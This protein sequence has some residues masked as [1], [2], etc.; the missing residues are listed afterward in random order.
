MQY[1]LADEYRFTWRLLLA[2]RQLEDT[3]SSFPKLGYDEELFTLHQTKTLVLFF[4][5]DI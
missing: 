1:I 4:F 2:C 3:H 5:R